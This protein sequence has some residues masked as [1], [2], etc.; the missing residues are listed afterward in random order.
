MKAVEISSLHSVLRESS[1]AVLLS[2][3]SI[4]LAA[5]DQSA[6]GSASDP[7]SPPA[8]VQSGEERDR[9]RALQ[10]EF[11]ARLDQDAVRFLAWV[12]NDLLPGVGKDHTEQML[13]IA[14]NPES[15]TEDL[16]KLT[17]A[18]DS[19][20]RGPDR[21]RFFKRCNRPLEILPEL[22]FVALPAGTFRMGSPPGERGRSDAEGPQREVRV[23]AFLLAAR[24]VT[25]AQFELFDPNHAREDWGRVSA[26]DDH[27]VVNVGWW[28]AYMFCR[29]LDARLPSEAEWEYACPGGHDY[30]LLIGRQHRRPGPCRLVLRQLRTASARRRHQA[31]Q[32][33]EA[34]RH[35]RQHLRVVPGHLARELRR[36]A[37]RRRCVDRQSL[38]K[39]RVPGRCLG[40]LRRVLPRTVSGGLVAERA[41]RLSRFSGGRNQ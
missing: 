23:R 14:T 9:I 16:G 20:G 24:T 4:A 30:A 17:L 1:A 18:L 39:A 28:D 35:A 36:C 6:A 40:L 32:R 15:S 34:A 27:P 26:L 3:P 37:H 7:T 10:L 29:W 41:Q 33:M 12:M 38:P 13:W 21:A 2:L 11:P 5:C 25:N 31:G 8:A 22:E 19:I